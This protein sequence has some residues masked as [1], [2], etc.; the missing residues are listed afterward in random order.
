MDPKFRSSFIPKKSLESAGVKATERYRTFNLFTFVGIAVFVI[1]LITSAISFGYQ[2]IIERNIDEKGIELEETLNEIN[3]EAIVSLKQIDNR[4]KTANLLL[5]EHITLSSFFEFLEES[6]LR[7][8]QFSSFIYTLD[9]DRLVK[10]SLEGKAQ[11]YNSLVLQSNIFENSDMLSNLNISDI[12][13]DDSGKVIFTVEA[14][15][16]KELLLYIRGSEESN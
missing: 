12:K 11:S 10:I 5:N 15:L 6:T 9:S 13:L 16:Q 2:F 7:N 8:I 3:P 1:T 4:I 14:T